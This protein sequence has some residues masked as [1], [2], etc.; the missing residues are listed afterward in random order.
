MENPSS[1][2]ILKIIEFN[3]TILKNLYKDETDFQAKIV[4]FKVN[5]EIQNTYWRPYM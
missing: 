2:E 3:Q 1:P 5:Q 4:N